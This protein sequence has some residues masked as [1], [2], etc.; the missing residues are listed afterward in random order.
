LASALRDL[1][2]R[3]QQI[4]KEDLLLKVIHHYLFLSTIIVGVSTG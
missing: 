1:G 4:T 2:N 3:R